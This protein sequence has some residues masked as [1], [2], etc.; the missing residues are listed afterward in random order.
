[1]TDQPQ[2]FT[3]GANVQHLTIAEVAAENPDY[4]KVLWTGRH[5]QIVAMTI[6]AGE[7]I[8]A[9]VHEHGD[10]ILTFISGTGHADLAGETH[11][12]GPGDQCAVPAGTE[13][14]FRNTGTEPLVLYT[15]YSPPERAAD[16]QFATKAA[17]DRAEQIGA[18]AP[19]QA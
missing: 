6:P 14:N 9:E 4:R 15:V 1:M 8:G 5:S 11:A 3:I 7:E 12:I 13:H 2:Q 10:Q 18:D 19:P 16:A 17:A